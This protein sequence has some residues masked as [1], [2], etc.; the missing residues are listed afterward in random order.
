MRTLADIGERDF[1]HILTRR[2]PS[3]PRV[4]LGAGDD[5]AVVRMPGSPRDWLLK[6][7]PLIE[8]V[9][10]LPH[11]PPEQVGRK[12]VA[13]VLSDL[14]AM[15]GDPHWA[16]ISLA[17][18]AGTRT[19]YLLR[20]Y[21]AACSCARRYRLAIVGGHLSQGPV[22]ELHVFAIGS[23]PRGSAVRRD[24]A[25]PDDWL[26]VTGTLGGSRL[27]RHLAF[28]PRLEQGRWLRH[29]VTAMIDVSDGLLSDLR[30]LLQRSGVGAELYLHR[31]PISAAAR[32]IHDGRTP[33]IH[34]LSDGED[35]ELLFTVSPRHAEHVLRAWRRRFSLRCSPIG[36][37]TATPELLTTREGDGNALCLGALH[38]YEHYR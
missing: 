2:L 18:P 30:Q 27:G 6:A 20:L 24:G 33:L 22:T 37:I 13:R 32:R 10:F 12:A 5:C 23:L 16:L 15:G 4:R 29:R 25:R 3:G 31:I 19:S 36:R 14:A 8:G 35:Y 34:A 28:T 38:G 7:D 17:A 11:D 21:R 26:F 9:H 1:I